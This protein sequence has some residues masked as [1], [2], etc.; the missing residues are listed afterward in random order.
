MVI[1]GSDKL[2]GFFSRRKGN[3]S[4]MPV[5]G[6]GGAG[7][8]EMADEGNG[9]YVVRCAAN[10][11][12]LA[13]MVNEQGEHFPGKT[14]QLGADIDL[15]GCPWL[16]IGKDLKTAFSG[17]FDGCGHTIGGINVL[18]SA[19]YAGFFGVIMGVDKVFTAEI[20]NLRLSGIRIAGREGNIY[21]G[22][23]AGYALDGVR[24]EKCVVGGRIE[25]ERCCGGIVGCAEDCVTVR[26]C[27]MRGKVGGKE[28][29]GALVGRLTVNSTLINCN[30]TA[31]DL[32]GRAEARYVGFCDDTSL[33]Q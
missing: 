32:W 28:V 26:Q 10:L 11:F 15:E 5:T 7:Y 2:F 3:V 4:E 30:N 9:R 19:P 6:T 22:G 8:Q 23:V 13:M 12:W 14:I 21:A 27:R 18:S 1:M 29:A 16:P 17:I 20:Y 25:G 33:E 31:T 24:I